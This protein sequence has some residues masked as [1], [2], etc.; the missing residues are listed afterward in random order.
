MK[1]SIRVISV[2]VVAL[3]LLVGCANKKTLEHVFDFE[4]KQVKVVFDASD[5]W[6]NDYGSGAVYIYD[7]PKSDDKEAIGYAYV[8]D[9]AEYDNWYAEYSEYEGFKALDNGF[10]FDNA[11]IDDP[12]YIYSVGDDVYFMITVNTGATQDPKAV[13]DRFKV[14]VVK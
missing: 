14:S 4:G 6:D 1:K 10:E 7:G 2:V 5:N 3:L 8:I 9:K 11:E 13:Y 12:R